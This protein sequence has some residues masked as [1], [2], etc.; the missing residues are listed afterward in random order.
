MGAVVRA[1]GTPSI[2]DVNRS[3]FT[4]TAR[5]R[6]FLMI[7]APR[8]IPGYFSRILHALSLRLLEILAAIEVTD[9]S[10]V[11]SH[12]NYSIGFNPDRETKTQTTEV[13]ATRSARFDYLCPK[14]LVRSNVSLSSA[15][16]CDRFRKVTLCRGIC[17]KLFPI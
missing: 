11:T 10:W 7:R 12:T 9:V 4:S 14:P 5:F 13:K 8:L 16:L 2:P 6:I 15:R 3:I 17:N 1:V